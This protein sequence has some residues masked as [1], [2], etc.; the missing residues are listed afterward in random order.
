[1]AGE[2]ALTWVGVHWQG[3]GCTNKEGVHQS[4]RGLIIGRDE[5]TGKRALAE[6]EEEARCQKAHWH[7]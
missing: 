2:G 3:R 7:L 6:E 4:E 5:G 1:M